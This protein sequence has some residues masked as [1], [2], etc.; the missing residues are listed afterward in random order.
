MKQYSFLMES[1]NKDNSYNDALEIFNE[2]SKEEKWDV[3][4]KS[5]TLKNVPVLY[6]HVIKNKAFI[7]LYPFEGH[8]NIGF[9]II[10]VNPTYRNQ[11]LTKQLLEQTKKDCKKIGITKLIWKCSNKNQ[12]SFKSALSNGFKQTF[13]TLEYD[14]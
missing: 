7:D 6:R 8:K 5:G 4:P 9:V 14:L 1:I 2:L 13:S 3:C 12:A 10:A 11:G